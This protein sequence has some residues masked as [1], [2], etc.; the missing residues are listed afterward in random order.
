MLVHS[1][2]AV[3]N[4]PG[5][6]EQSPENPIYYKASEALVRCTLHSTPETT[7]LYTFIPFQSYIIVDH[8]IT[9]DNNVLP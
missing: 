2:A 8:P 9:S 4:F 7:L 5:L 3:G 6:V 1:T